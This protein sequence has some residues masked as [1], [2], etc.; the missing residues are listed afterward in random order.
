MKPTAVL[1][2]T[3]RGQVVDQAALVRAL[4]QGSIAGAGLDV[5]EREPLEADSPLLLME[6]V[7]LSPHVG[8][9]TWSTRSKMGELTARNLLAALDGG[10]PVYCVNPETGKMRRAEC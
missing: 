7:T 5:Y 10:M 9:A 8:S 1:I 2:N 6:N 4:K 3:C